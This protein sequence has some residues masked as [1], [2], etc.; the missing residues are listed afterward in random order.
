MRRI[1]SQAKAFAEPSS[2]PKKP[3]PASQGAVRSLRAQALNVDSARAR[4]M[5]RQD[6]PILKCPSRARARKAAARFTIASRFLILQEEVSIR[7]H[8]LDGLR[9]A[10]QF[11][12]L[13][14]VQR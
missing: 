9:L 7:V 4:I 10:G 6:N 2:Q 12:Q 5:A 8:E 11:L 3:E 1:G 13:L 14:R